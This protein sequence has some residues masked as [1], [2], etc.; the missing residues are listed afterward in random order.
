LPDNQWR[1]RGQRTFHSP[2]L[3]SV[4]NH[5][6]ECQYS[7]LPPRLFGIF[8][9]GVCGR[10][11]MECILILRH[12]ITKVGSNFE[13]VILF[14]V[15]VANTVYRGFYV[16]LVCNTVDNLCKGHLGRT[17]LRPH[18]KSYISYTAQRK[19]RNSV[20]NTEYSDIESCLGR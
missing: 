15:F 8:S 11:P 7:L 1:N 10:Y 5:C 20:L 19:A 17:F 18:P 12:L 2:L 16:L 9:G 14:R 3:R 13:C 6:Y 4:A